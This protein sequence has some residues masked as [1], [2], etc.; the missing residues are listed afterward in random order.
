MSDSAA[1]TIVIIETTT[2]A[3]P[4]TTD[5]HIRFLED[6]RNVAWLSVSCAVFGGLGLFIVYL[7]V[8]YG[9]IEQ[10]KKCCQRSRYTHFVMILRFYLT[11]MYLSYC[12]VEMSHTVL[13]IKSYS[14]CL[15]PYPFILFF[16][17]WS[18][19]KTVPRDSQTFRDVER[20]HGKNSNKRNKIYTI[21]HQSD[22]G[23]LLAKFGVK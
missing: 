17:Y 12:I 21:I 10:L 6:P 18:P 22:I 5:R 14:F 11:Y 13:F 16:F 15:Q 2:V 19:S 4:T 20:K 7:V 9:S 8:R 1:I 23:L 3:I